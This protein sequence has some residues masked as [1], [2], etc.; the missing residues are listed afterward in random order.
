MSLDPV[1]KLFCVVHFHLTCQHVINLSSMSLDLSAC[2]W[3]C[4]HVM[5]PVNMSFCLSNMSL[6]PYLNRRSGWH[7]TFSLARAKIFV[8]GKFEK[9]LP[10]PYQP[11]SLGYF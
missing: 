2:H 3:T 6:D 5:G 1:L 4:Q 11:T 8:G 9:F 7:E 10:C